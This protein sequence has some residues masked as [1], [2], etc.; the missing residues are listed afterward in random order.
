MLGCTVPVL[1]TVHFF[2]SIMLWNDI[3]FNCPTNMKLVNG[4]ADFYCKYSECTS[5]R[6][7]D[8][9]KFYLYHCKNKHFPMA[10]FI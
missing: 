5:S 8:I 10:W 7:C 6:T 3:V 1:V 9:L 2:L 4:S